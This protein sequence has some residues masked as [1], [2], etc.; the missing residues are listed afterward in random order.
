MYLR[1]KFLERQAPWR[2]VESVGRNSRRR[3]PP[4]PT[5][6]P[7]RHVLSCSS[8]QTIVARSFRAA[9]GSS[10]LICWR[11]G[12][13][14]SSTISRRCARRSPGLGGW[15]WAERRVWGVL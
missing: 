9:A 8:C 10:R 1:R 14:Y 15:G 3:N 7:V 13:P 12:K 6:P 4:P 11:G 2:L 5:T